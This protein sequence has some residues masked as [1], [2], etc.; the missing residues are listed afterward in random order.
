MR[1][2][3]NLKI[4]SLIQQELNKLIFR[5]LDLNGALVTITEVEVLEDLKEAK[6]K[7]SILPND[8]VLEIFNLLENNRRELQFQLIR[9]MNIRPIPHL[10]FVLQEEKLAT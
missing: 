3:R 9:K 2:Y 4:A 1:P 7:V 6:V 5:N 8:K 10:K